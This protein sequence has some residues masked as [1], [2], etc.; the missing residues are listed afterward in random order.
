MG[1]NVSLLCCASHGKVFLCQRGEVFLF[2][3][4]FCFNSKKILADHFHFKVL[5]MPKLP[6]RSSLFSNHPMKFPVRFNL[7]DFSNSN[8]YNLW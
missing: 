4:F 3:V 8:A 6:S 1:L 5:N 2:S 7:I